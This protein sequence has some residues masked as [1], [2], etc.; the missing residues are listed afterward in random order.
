MQPVLD[1]V[2]VPVL[3]VLISLTLFFLFV[4]IFGPIPFTITSVVTNKVDLFTI[5]GTGEASGVPSTAEFSVGVS[6]TGS[7]V[8]AVQEQVNLATNKIVE[9]LKKLGI[10]DKEIKTSDYAV[11]PNIDYTSSRQTTTGYTV[12]STI[13]V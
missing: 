13:N 1:Q 12:N 2:K 4:R 9:E 6:K 5:E 8:V 11:T 10:N 7:T 3:T